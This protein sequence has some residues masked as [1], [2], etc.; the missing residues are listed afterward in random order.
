MSYISSV[1]GS[2]VLKF[3]NFRYRGNMGRSDVNIN[4]AVKMPDL[5]K[6]LFGATSVVLSLVLAEF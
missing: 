6:P 2:F 1:I 5:E 3:P 4:A